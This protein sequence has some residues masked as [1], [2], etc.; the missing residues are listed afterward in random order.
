MPQR[1][2]GI[3]VEVERRTSAAPEL[4]LDR[5]PLAGDVRF[6]N[7]LFGSQPERPQADESVPA[8]GRQCNSAE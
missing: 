7:K 6:V 8:F 5:A 3:A 4:N 2:D 1:E